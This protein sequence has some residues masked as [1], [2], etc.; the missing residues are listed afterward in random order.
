MSATVA[1]SYRPSEYEVVA[2]SKILFP[3]M[4]KE[5]LEWF[6]RSWDTKWDRNPSATPW[7]VALEDY[8]F[9]AKFKG[10]A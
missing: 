7:R 5:A 4:T 3:G 9:T 6:A 10:I 8:L 1:A 2:W